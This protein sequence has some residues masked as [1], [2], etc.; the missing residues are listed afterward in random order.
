MKVSWNASSR[1]PIKVSFLFIMCTHQSILSYFCKRSGH[2]VPHRPLIMT[3]P[4]LKLYKVDSSLVQYVL[5]PCLVFSYKNTIVRFGPRGYF[6]NMGPAV[7]IL[8]VFHQRPVGR[9]GWKP[10]NLYWLRSNPIQLHGF[11]YPVYWVG[12]VGLVLPVFQNYG[13]DYG[14]AWLICE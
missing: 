2:L 13:V 14:F 6:I 4:L 12:L 1:V 11:W 9:L 7:A 8:G 5:G 3:A 10:A